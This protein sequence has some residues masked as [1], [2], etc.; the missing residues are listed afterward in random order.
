MTA[1]PVLRKLRPVGMQHGMEVAME[2]WRRHRLV[3][4]GL[5]CLII[6]FA[7]VACEDERGGR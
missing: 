4:M 3:G 5:L 1:R 6:V 7:F 2:A